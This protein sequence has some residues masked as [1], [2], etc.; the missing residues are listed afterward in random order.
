[1]IYEHLMQTN[2]FLLASIAKYIAVSYKYRE[3]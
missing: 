3:S 2:L 1:M